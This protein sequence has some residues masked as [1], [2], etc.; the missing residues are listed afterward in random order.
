MSSVDV[1]IRTL[2]DNLL[3]NQ[4]GESE[5]VLLRDAFELSI[6]SEVIE[7]NLKDVVFG[8]LMGTVQSNFL[9]LFRTIFNRNPNREEIKIAV[10]VYQK[11]FARIKKRID[12]TFSCD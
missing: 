8:Y 1:I 11:N 12:D 6:P 3:D 5:L 7:G 4:L 2:M 9:S 10:D